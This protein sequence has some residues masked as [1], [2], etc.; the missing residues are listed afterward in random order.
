PLHEIPLAGGGRGRPPPRPSPRRPPPWPPSP[1]APPGPPPG[2][3]AGGAPAAARGTRG[4]HERVSGRHGRYD[5]VDLGVSTARRAVSED[6]RLLAAMR[7][8]LRS[9]AAIR[10]AAAR[11]SLYPRVI[12]L[13]LGFAAISPLAAA[14][15]ELLPLPT[16]ARL[17][18]LPAMLV[19]VVTGVR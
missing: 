3:G 14:Y 15:A 7:K 13:V 19:L 6:E 11:S 16:G 12:F 17:F 4:K 1:P 2:A 9:L 8:L 5:P 18:L 10:R